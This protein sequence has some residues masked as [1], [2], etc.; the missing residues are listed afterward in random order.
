MIAAAGSSRRPFAH[1]GALVP[2][3][4]VASV[5]LGLLLS[6]PSDRVAA[7]ATVFLG[8]FF[9]ALPFLLAG[10][11]VSAAIQVWAP[12]RWFDTLAAPGR[13]RGALAGAALGAL[14]PV[15][16]CGVAPVARRLLARGASFSSGLGFLLAGPVVNPI[17]FAATW[18]AFGPGLALARVGTSLAIAVG[19]AWLLGAH[20]AP[21]AL[22]RPPP[23]GDGGG[24]AC[25]ADAP[26]AG[27]WDRLLRTGGLAADELVDIGRLLVVGAALAALLR[28]A[29]PG[30]ALLA[31]VDQPTL[32]VPTAMGLA[33]LLS[34]C[35]VVD[36]FVALSFAGAVPTGALLAFLVFGPVVDVKSVAL[37]G[38]IFRWRLVAVVVVLVAQATLLAGLVVALNVG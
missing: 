23:A 2:A 15:C 28:T 29:V 33:A 6:E 31:A 35:S 16:E 5:A 18:T 24:D 20:P 4:V 19:V 7:F 3:A 17:V 8:I 26:S 34:I 10:A 13:L 1:A 38:A 37:Y 36:A 27:R 30:P 32:L 9:E 21:A 12:T 22:L 11:L 14:L 25:D